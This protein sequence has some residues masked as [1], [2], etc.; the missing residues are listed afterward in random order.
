MS[1]YYQNLQ[2]QIILEEIKSIID[3]RATYGYRHVTT[4]IN[5]QRAADG[6]NK[7]NSSESRGEHRHEWIITATENASAKASTLWRYN[8]STPKSTFVLG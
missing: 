8:Y 1:R 6:H 5:R 4:S 2:E 7:N 3:I